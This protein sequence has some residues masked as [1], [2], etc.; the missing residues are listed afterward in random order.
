VETSTAVWVVLALVVAVLAVQLVRTDR[1]RGHLADRAATTRAEFE[2]LRRET[3]QALRTR[4]MVLD[5]TTDGIL[6][7]GPGGEVALA[8]GALGGQLGTVPTSADTV[9]PL[10][11]R[12]AIARSRETG[13]PASTLIETGAPSRW[14]RS[15]V[16]PAAEGHTLVLVRDVTEQR[17]L[18]AARRDFVDNASHELK[19]PVTTVQA[20][21]DTLR[22]IARDD[23]ASVPR[24]TDQ[25]ERETARLSRI[26]ADLL[27]LSRLESGRSPEELVSFSD[28][29]T[30]EAPRLV[31]AAERAGVHL[32]VDAAS[33]RSVRGSARDLSLLVRNLVDNAIRY[34]P[35]GSNV[36]VEVRDERDEVVLRVGDDGIGIPTR[37]LPR[38]FERF[39]RVD[40]AR[41]R[42]TGGTGL[43]LAIVKHVVENHGGRTSVE[44]ELGRGTTFEVRL[45]AVV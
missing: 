1:A 32:D 11:L 23:P 9:L 19:T 31:E 45:P 36:V 26:V 27:D 15:T 24:F 18:E 12:R 7:I 42:E 3:E 2:Q 6:L 30:E 25:L 28:V 33:E 20:T 8:N 43:G 10:E 17:R 38:I 37:D 5:T 41:S 44:S 40:R 13:R 4:D 29:V 16:E 14:L 34:S 35:E 21:V 39:Y 22:R